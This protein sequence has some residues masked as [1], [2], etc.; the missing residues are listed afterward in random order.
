M[1]TYRRRRLNI[2]VHTKVR[3][4]ENKNEPA[5]SCPRTSYFLPVLYFSYVRVFV[6]FILRDAMRY[7]NT[8]YILLLHLLCT[9]AFFPAGTMTATWSIQ[10]S[11]CGSHITCTRFPIKESMSN[12]CTTKID[13]DESASTIHINT[14]HV[15]T[16]IYAY[17]SYDSYTHTTHTI[18][19]LKFT[20]HIAPLQFIQSI[21]FRT[22]AYSS[23]YKCFVQ[24]AR[25]QT[26]FEVMVRVRYWA[27]HT[28]Q[29]LRK[30]AATPLR[31]IAPARFGSYFFWVTRPP[32]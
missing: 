32:P 1:F 5:L 13:G 23:V 24:L 29:E 12:K 3:R 26:F 21:H 30:Y 14:T 31:G 18:R 20:Q 19:L 4:E 15:N 25:E 17:N 22:S 2:F 27:P 28:C 9:W 6:F 8:W 16:P 11:T 7:C 10:P